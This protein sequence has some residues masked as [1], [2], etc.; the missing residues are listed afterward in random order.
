ML[1]TVLSLAILLLCL[2]I[3]ADDASK[4]TLDQLLATNYEAQGGK[5]ELKA[6]D[7][8]VMTGTMNVA[9]TEAPFT[10]TAKRPGKVRMEFTM[11]GM[12]GVQAY[13]G[14]TAW[15]VMPFMGTTDHPKAPA[16][17]AKSII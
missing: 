12:T 13:D 4:M 11:Q 6:V 10:I 1:Q 2:P 14:E 16:D 9:G 17:Q 3:S 15:M 7:T 5:T 8:L